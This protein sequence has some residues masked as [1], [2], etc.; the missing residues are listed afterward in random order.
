VEIL[1]AAQPVLSMEQLFTQRLA[2]YIE[3]LEAT[4][5]AC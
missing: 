1:A 2:A 3:L 5:P 4:C